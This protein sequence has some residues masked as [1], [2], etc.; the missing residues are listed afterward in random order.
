MADL[1][2]LFVEGPFPPPA[3]WSAASPAPAPR[4]PEAARNEVPFVVALFHRSTL[5]TDASFKIRLPHRY[6]V[7]FV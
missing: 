1:F 6:S 3:A 2:Y 4:I 7:N 5:K